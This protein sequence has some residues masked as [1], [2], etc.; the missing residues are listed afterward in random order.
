MSTGFGVR[1]LY[2]GL[3]LAPDSCATLTQVFNHSGSI[4]PSGKPKDWLKPTLRSF[5]ARKNFQFLDSFEN[6]F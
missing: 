5:P 6:G 1:G 3:A 4:S 2:Y